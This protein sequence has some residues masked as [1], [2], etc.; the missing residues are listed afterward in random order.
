MLTD[1]LQ[2]VGS[3]AIYLLMGLNVSGVVPPPP[4]VTGQGGLHIY[5]VNPTTLDYT[6]ITDSWRADKNFSWT[7]GM[8]PTQPVLPPRAGDANFSMDNVDGS[9]DP[10]T[11]TLPQGAYIAAWWEY[12][13]TMYPLWIGAVDAPVQNPTLGT[14]DVDFTAVGFF[15]RFMSKPPL[16][17]GDLSTQVYILQRTDQIINVI[18]DQINWPSGQRL[19]DVGETIIAYWWA[20]GKDAWTALLEMVASEGPEAAIYEDPYGNFVFKNRSATTTETRMTVSQ[21]T[22]TDAPGDNHT[23]LQHARPFRYI[24]AQNNVINYAR[25]VVEE[26]IIDTVVPGIW[27][28]TGPFTLAANE[29]RS[30]GATSDSGD[31]FTGTLALVDPDNYHVSAGSAT[32]TLDR[33][34]GQ[35]VTVTAVAGAGGATIDYLNIDASPFTVVQKTTYVNTTGAPVDTGVV[36]QNYNGPT[37]PGI[38]SQYARDNIEDMVT[39]WANGRPV[40]VLTLININNNVLIQQITREIL[41]RVTVVE[42]QLQINAD[43]LIYAMRQEIAPGP[44]ITETLWLVEAP[45]GPW[46]PVGR[47][48]ID[49][50]TDTSHTRLVISLSA[51]VAYVFGY[52]GGGPLAADNG[53]VY[54]KT[55]DGGAT[56]SAPVAWSID[57]TVHSNAAWEIFYEG[58]LAGGRSNIV[59]MVRADAGT[60]VRGVYYRQLD[61][62]TD[63]LSAEVT[64][65]T[66]GFGSAQPAV[67]FSISPDL[68]TLGI[69]WETNTTDEGWKSVDDGVTW[70][71]QIAVMGDFSQWC[72]GWP[73]YSAGTNNLLY[74]VFNQVFNQLYISQVNTT[75]NTKADTNIV[76]TNGELWSN[77]IANRPLNVSTCM[78]TEGLIFLAFWDYADGSSNELKVYTV[79]GAIATAKTSPITA[80][81]YCRAVAISYFNGRLYVIYGRDPAGASF[82]NCQL[83]YKYS[84]DLGTTWSA[85]ASYNADAVDLRWI[86]VD[87][88]PSVALQ[89]VWADST[90]IY[91]E[92]PIIP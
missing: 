90:K 26:R 31:P 82:S 60:G 34:S 36:Q 8:D 20:E 11:T 75:A 32:V 73:D 3:A 64:V 48:E 42:T 52:Y 58:R 12:S 5:L 71:S 6:E 39:L 43:Y 47:V 29:T 23:S 83:Y 92:V 78:T 38:F 77:D 86:G 80:T 24:D 25:W 66:G 2:P 10:T 81:T 17:H 16:G 91:T 18:L 59:H 53:L 44:L 87:Q 55:V 45:A 65:T 70:S 62:D 72:V 68:T 88:K 76:V 61:L 30:W 9:L 41:D 35:V 79:L 22:F 50:G 85:E 37:Y 13:G 89:A 69:Q 19:L 74:L 46:T 49:D 15:S 14:E 54:W 28:I 40:L 63:T 67:A 56:W 57:T 51:T 21:A 4:P 7:R 84:D 27:T 33:Q 1:G